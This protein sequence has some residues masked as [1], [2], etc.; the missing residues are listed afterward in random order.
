MTPASMQALSVLRQMG[1][2]QWYLVPLLAFVIYVYAVEIEKKNWNGVLIGLL[3]YTSEF[4][5]EMLNAL[6]L[7][8]TRHSA[9]W[10]T[11]GNSA[12]LILVGLTVEISMM[13]LVAGVIVTK[14]LPADR[15]LK[16]LGLPN[17]ILIP[18]FWGIFCTLVEVILNRW[19]ALVWEYAWW[20]WP[21]I[22]LLF[23]GYTAPFLVITWLYDRFTIKLK[24]RL[25]GIFVL[26]DV[27]M[28]AIFVSILKWI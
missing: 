20:R 12:F 18:V 2:F 25:L 11:P 17:R 23:V 22:F 26:I 15:D 28:W 5:W 19:G 7:H 24:A 9:I 27:I 8:F 1:H 3:L 4:C 10:T 6:V 14:T 21:N 16:I 13:F